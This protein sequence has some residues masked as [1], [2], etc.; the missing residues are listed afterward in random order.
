MLASALLLAIA[1]VE[2][3]AQ[4]GLPSPP[5]PRAAD[6]VADLVAAGRY[7]DAISAL[8]AAVAAHPEDTTLLVRLGV[9]YARTRRPEA[10]ATFKRVLE[11]DARDPHAL[12]NIDALVDLGSLELREKRYREAVEHLDAARARG[13]HGVA[14][15]IRLG[16]AHES[17]AELEAARE[18]YAAAVDEGAGP[19]ALLPLGRLLIKLGRHQEAE[20][21][22]L[23]AVAARPRGPVL[24]LELGRARDKLGRGDEA[25]AA[26]Q[27]SIEYDGAAPEPHYALGTL[28]VRRG[29]TDAGQAEL[30]RFKELS[31]ARDA[32][33]H[34]SGQI[35]TLNRAGLKLLADGRTLDAIETFEQ[36]IA[37]GPANGAVHAN[38]GGALLS[39]GNA[40]GALVALE[41]AIK[42]GGDVDAFRAL[43]AR[44]KQAAAPSS[45]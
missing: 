16:V 36:A 11:R 21:V 33:D 40:R 45:R 30:R 39:V 15:F 32:T 25:E 18:A 31:D 44:A 27:K 22:L 38:L 8:E 20:V 37:L 26:Y 34:L 29:Q 5:A 35:A 17:L 14:L 19:E 24:W 7:V 42:R 6:E 13:A 2:P 43:L 4:P 41:E 12:P 1:T 3:P 10:E 9:L 23:K 28:L